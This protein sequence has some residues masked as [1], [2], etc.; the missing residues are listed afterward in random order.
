MRR[1]QSCSVLGVLGGLEC[2][3]EVESWV[4][5][6]ESSASAE[7][8]SQDF[9]ETLEYHRPESQPETL[10]YLPQPCENMGRGSGTAERDGPS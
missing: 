10:E 1:L 8:G 5:Q 9:I 4:L 3:P 7:P 2:S 6:P